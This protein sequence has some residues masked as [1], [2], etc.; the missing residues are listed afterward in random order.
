MGFGT[1]SSGHQTTSLKT[2]VLR[3]WVTEP[4]LVHSIDARRKIVGA[5]KRQVIIHKFRSVLRSQ[6]AN[7]KPHCQAICLS[8]VHDRHRILNHPICGFSLESN[9]EHWRA[10]S[11]LAIVNEE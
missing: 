10:S 2:E 3:V 4:V 6:K 9:A 7:I 11:N 5:C 8:G 1:V